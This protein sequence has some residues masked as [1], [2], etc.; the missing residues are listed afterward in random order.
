MVR[1]TVRIALTLCTSHSC[2]NLDSTVDFYFF[3]ETLYSS[4]ISEKQMLPVFHI[5][6]YKHESKII[7]NQNQTDYMC[8][9][10]SDE[11]DLITMYI[12]TFASSWAL[13]INNLQFL[14]VVSL[15]SH[16]HTIK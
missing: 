7:E 3:S 12:I 16:Q 2:I 4:N 13:Q 5:F 9:R 11:T 14:N 8:L 6:I 1:I 15:P 10:G